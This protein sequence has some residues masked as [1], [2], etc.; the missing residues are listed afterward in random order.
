MKRTSFWVVGV[1]GLVTLGAAMF[2]AASHPH[3]HGV[4][5]D[6]AVSLLLYFL[7]LW[8]LVQF[9]RLSVAKRLFVSL[10]VPLAILGVL[11]GI[12]TSHNGF[13]AIPVAYLWAM[14]G[15]SLA[16][17]FDEAAERRA[18]EQ[19]PDPCPL[20]LLELAATTQLSVA[21]V[22]VQPDGKILTIANTVGGLREATK[23][24]RFEPDGGVDGTFGR[25]HSCIS[26]SF[27]TLLVDERGTIVLF[28]D[29]LI[30]SEPHLVLLTPDG[31]TATRVD[32]APG[33]RV[34]ALQLDGE[35]LLGLVPKTNRI[36]EVS[37]TSLEAPREVFDLGP[38]LASLGPFSM[39]SFRASSGIWL[40]A[41]NRQLEHDQGLALQLA[42]LNPSTGHVELAGG[43]LDRFDD[44]YE[45]LPSGDVLTFS[46]GFNWRVLGP[47][48]IERRTQSTEAEATVMT[49]AGPLFAGWSKARGLYFE[50]MGS[51]STRPSAR[52]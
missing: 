23:L 52:E 5:F 20:T 29:K 41:L 21:A 37:R 12:P 44:V 47:D 13:V 49:P 9:T 31:R 19:A 35:R 28:S 8:A 34:E 38:A 1:A 10:A 27:D 48:S 40:L 46:P 11:L 3:E 16:Q 18:V 17:V 50:L 7:V 32:L 45:P 36:I 4:L 26:R 14:P 43:S 2:W 6:G 22:A 24:T 42:W 30:M 15:L 33:V 25:T 39:R 51:T